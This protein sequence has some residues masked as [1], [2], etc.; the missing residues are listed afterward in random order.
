MERL[1]TIFAPADWSCMNTDKLR[2]YVGGYVFLKLDGSNA[3]ARLGFQADTR[4]FFLECLPD[5]QSDDAQYVRVADLTTA[6]ITEFEVY[7]PALISS[8]LSLSWKKPKDS[9]ARYSNAGIWAGR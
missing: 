1:V 6:N 3:L 8:S 9:K 4:V 7:G 5:P 2:N